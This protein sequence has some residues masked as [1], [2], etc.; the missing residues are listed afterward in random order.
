MRRD[1][2]G[3]RKIATMASSAPT[4]QES[5]S[6]FARW[7]AVA[8]A[9]VVL[10]WVGLW[11]VGGPTIGDLLGPVTDDRCERLASGE[12]DRNDRDCHEQG[13]VES[14]NWGQRAP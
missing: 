14:W 7:L 9:A 4:P 13:Y 8:V 12:P 5:W 2:G 10:V 1:I 3:F 6:A 11:F